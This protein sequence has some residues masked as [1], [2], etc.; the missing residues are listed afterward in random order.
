MRRIAFVAALI[1][2]CGSA[3]AAPPMVRAQIRPMAMIV[4]PDRATVLFTRHSARLSPVGRNWVASESQRLS[5]G[6]LDPSAVA[7]DAA[8]SC[9]SAL[10]TC[11]GADIDALIMIVM[12]QAASDADQDLKD[13]LAEV[14]AKN[15]EK[16]QMRAALQQMRMSR[17]KSAREL[18]ADMQSMKYDLDSM[19]EMGETESM[20]LQMAMDRY[21]KLME[22]LSNIMKK[23]SETND[24]IIKN[25]K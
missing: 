13:I 24:N 15:S 10:G 12:M 22:A 3:L 20:R 23:M 19:S 1:C 9:A 16:S 25:L 6:A 21:S 7:G 11:T 14:K 17:V 2:V 5:S 8:Q 4:V 18:N